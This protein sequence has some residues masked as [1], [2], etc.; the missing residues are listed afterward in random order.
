MS[1]EKPTAGGRISKRQKGKLTGP[2]QRPA[3]PV[4]KPTAAEV[5]ASARRRR[6]VSGMKWEVACTADPCVC[7]WRGVRRG[8]RYE[9]E[10]K[11]CPRC[12]RPTEAVGRSGR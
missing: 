12:G 1:F 5:A 3:P 11:P 2:A 8:S 10:A 6:G 9:A 4:K 7:W